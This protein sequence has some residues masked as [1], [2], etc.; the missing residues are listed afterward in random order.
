MDNVEHILVVFPDASLIYRRKK[1]RSKENMDSLYT[2]KK[3]WNE[4]LSWPSKMKSDIL[5]E[6]WYLIVDKR[7]RIILS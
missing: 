1:I 3:N 5:L 2:E 4:K 7:E 6:K